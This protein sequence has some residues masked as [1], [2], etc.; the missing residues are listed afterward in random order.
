MADEGALDCK[1]MLKSEII[2]EV[3]DQK[4]DVLL[5]EYFNTDCA[6][7]VAYKLN[8]SVFVGFSSW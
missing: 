4:F 7:G 5:T 3:N 2:D 1:N 6:L 8:I